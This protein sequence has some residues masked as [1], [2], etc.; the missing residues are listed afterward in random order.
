MVSFMIFL[1]QA[2]KLQ[3]FQNGANTHCIAIDYRKGHRYV[4]QNDSLHLYLV[5]NGGW[6]GIVELK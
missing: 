1:E 5:R 4:T 2:G 3:S 6:C